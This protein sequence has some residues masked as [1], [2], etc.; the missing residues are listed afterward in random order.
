MATKYDNKTMLERFEEKYIKQPSGCWEWVAAHHERGYGYFYTSKEYS[1][2]KMD[3]AHRVSLF[4]YKNE[5]DDTKSVLH[6]CDNTKCVNPAH[7]RWGSHQDN[8]SDMVTKK[9]F[10]HARQRLTR[11]DME[12]A[13]KM[14]KRGVM[15]KDIAKHF[16]IDDSHASRLSRGL[17][18]QFNKFEE[19]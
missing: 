9:R 10:K 19:N 4:L 14:R 15:I 11:A 3:F 17:I 13:I 8:M 5:R 6:S 12:E 2:R 1:N 7:L 18:K 16:D